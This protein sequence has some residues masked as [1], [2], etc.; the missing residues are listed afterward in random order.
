VGQQNSHTKNNHK[1][2]K[3]FINDCTEK[4]KLIT[5]SFFTFS[6]TTNPQPKN[7]DN[8]SDLDTITMDELSYLNPLQYFSSLLFSYLFSLLSYR[9]ITARREA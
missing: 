1:K 8:R 2:T 7:S 3:R 9:N 6:T 4:G 5:F